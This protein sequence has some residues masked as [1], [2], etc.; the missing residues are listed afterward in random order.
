M[1]SSFPE[2]W[3]SGE[4]TGIL[5]PIVVSPALVVLPNSSIVGTSLFGDGR[6]GSCT[7]AR[8]RPIALRVRRGCHRTRRTSRPEAEWRTSNLRRI[9]WF[10]ALDAAEPATRS[11]VQTP[12][13]ESP[14]IDPAHRDSLADEPGCAG[15][16]RVQ[17]V[18]HRGIARSPER[19]PPVDDPP[20]VGGRNRVAYNFL[21][22]GYLPPVPA[23]A[24]DRA[25][26]RSAFGT[27]RWGIPE[28]ISFPSGE[29]ATRQTKASSKVI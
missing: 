17:Q 19:A 26:E 2:G 24:I 25:N 16:F 27:D 8:R 28:Q 29:K 21:A 11:I 12:T 22:R 20:A 15:V 18:R 4:L 13:D 7:P 1:I 23:V 5:H 10:S 6:L 14:L 9:S 3:R